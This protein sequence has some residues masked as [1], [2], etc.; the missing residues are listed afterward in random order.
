MHRN[1]NFV[2]SCSSTP[3]TTAVHGVNRDSVICVP[4]E[5]PVSVDNC[6]EFSCEDVVIPVA[7]KREPV[8][9]R[10]WR[11][12]DGTYFKY[13]CFS[14]GTEYKPGGKLVASTSHMKSCAGYHCF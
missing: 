3:T 13:I 1:N 6:S 9:G 14:D 5:I 8:R 12:Y 4:S 10:A 2:F 11:H 7:G